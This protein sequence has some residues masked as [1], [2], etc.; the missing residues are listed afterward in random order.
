M[1][2]YENECVGC[3]SWMGCRGDSCPNRHVAH[4][5]CDK[6]RYEFNPDELFVVDGEWLCEDCLKERYK[7]VSDLDEDEY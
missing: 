1:I 2:E 5:I 6:C 3:E 7:K 4:F